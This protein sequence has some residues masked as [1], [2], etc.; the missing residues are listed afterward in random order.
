MPDFH[1]RTGIH[2]GEKHILATLHPG[3]PL[4]VSILD[5]LSY[6]ECEREHLLLSLPEKDAIEFQKER[7]VMSI[8]IGPF[9]LLQSQSDFPT[10]CAPDRIEFAKERLK[11]LIPDELLQV[12]RDLKHQTEVLREQET[13]IGEIPA[14]I[15]AGQAL[16]IADF[17]KSLKKTDA[18]LVDGIPT[19]RSIE[20][21]IAKALHRAGTSYAFQHR[22]AV[23]M[24]LLEELSSQLEP[25]E[26]ARR[27]AEF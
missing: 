27:V 11:E 12:A 23:V 6:E 9:H 18:A 3:I 16:K 13:P 5:R 15:F 2:P 8:R 10:S 21:G 4:T 22:Q 14:A 19:E 20:P 17:V 1:L 26:L 25:S 24:D 7:I